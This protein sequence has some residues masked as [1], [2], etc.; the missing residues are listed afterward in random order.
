MVILVQ[1]TDTKTIPAPSSGFPS[2]VDR[3]T[4]GLWVAWQVK[5]VARGSRVGVSSCKGKWC[6][7]DQFPTDQSLKRSI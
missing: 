5:G 3:K 2:I 7:G 6:W 1:A 4:A